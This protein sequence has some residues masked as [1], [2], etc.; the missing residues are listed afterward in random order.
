MLIW[1]GFIASLWYKHSILQSCQA[2]LVTR[3]ETFA[4]VFTWVCQSCSLTSNLVWQTELVTTIDHLCNTEPFERH[5]ESC[6]W[7][8]ETFSPCG[9]TN[10]TNSSNRLIFSARIRFHFS[11]E[12]YIRWPGT[13]GPTKGFKLPWYPPLWTLFHPSCVLLF[14]WCSFPIGVVWQAQDALQ[15]EVAHLQS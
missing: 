9:E 13:L 2:F 4:S 5:I 14:M 3:W 1:P 8:P 12:K 6:L 15:L 10:M 7:R 11:H